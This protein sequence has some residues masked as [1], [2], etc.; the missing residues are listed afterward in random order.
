MDFKWPSSR[1]ERLVHVGY[2]CSR[3]WF[4][5]KRILNRIVFLLLVGSQR[6][7]ARDFWDDGGGTTYR[8]IQPHFFMVF[9]ILADSLSSGNYNAMHSMRLY[10]FEFFLLKITPNPIRGNVEI[11]RFVISRTKTI[12]R[13]REGEQIIPMKLKTFWA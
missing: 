11:N 8:D 2:C 7:S 3:I 6:P 1:V 13:I 5:G 10:R 4:Y 12:N 9:S